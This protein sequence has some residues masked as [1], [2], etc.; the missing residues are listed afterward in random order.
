MIDLLKEIHKDN[1]YKTFNHSLYSYDLSGWNGESEIFQEL[2]M[3][4]DPSLILEI[5]S[6]KGQSSKNM[7]SFLKNA[8]LKCKIICVDTWLGSVEF[9]NSDTAERDTYPVSGFPQIYYQF[10]SNVMKSG[11]EDIII[12]FPQTSSNAC[13][14]LE[15]KGVQCDLIYIDGSNEY[16]DIVMDLECCWPLLKKEGV[17]FGDDYS[18]FDHIKRAVNE[19][20]TRHEQLDNLETHDND[21][22]WLI[23]KI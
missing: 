5:G 8:G 20:C 4:Q 11:L 17:I 14:W 6:W 21:I 10:L 13:R 7:G 15:N 3:M 19:F 2:I 9:I 23:K 16:R 1:P 12:P 22:F 18:H